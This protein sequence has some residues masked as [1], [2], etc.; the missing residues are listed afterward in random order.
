MSLKQILFSDLERQ[1]FYEGN[2]DKPV[3]LFGVLK[4]SLNPRFTPVLFWRISHHLYVSG[5]TPLA[6]VVSLINFFVF[7]IEIGLRC[8]IGEGLYLPHTI[9]TVIG[10]N[11]IGQNVIIFQGVTLGAKELDLGY[12]PDQR[13]S[14][15]NNVT[16]GSGAKV[17]GGIQI[18]D[19][20]QIGANAVVTKS[21]PDNVVVAGVPARII[22]NIII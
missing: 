21:V 6:K 1:Y 10:A 13:P 18:G 9:G 14:I 7:G 12:Q 2:K 11:R 17:L 15:G 5:L 16:I 22:R 8:E 20:V 19:N 3:T 4:R